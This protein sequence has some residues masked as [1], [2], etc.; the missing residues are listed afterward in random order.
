MIDKQLILHTVGH[1]SVDAICAAVIF[2]HISDPIYSIEFSEEHTL[3][4]ILL[5]NLLAFATQPVAGRLLDQKAL[6]SKFVSLSFIPLMVAALPLLNIW[7]KIILLGI[8]NSMFHT[9]AGSIVIK[10]ETDK[11]AP[12][13]IFVSSGALGL[14]TGTIFG[15]ETI[16]IPLLLVLLF[17]MFALSF[18]L[19]DT[20]PLRQIKL[21]PPINEKAVFF[22]SICIAIRSFFGFLP[23]T[24]FSKTT[25][26]A[27]MIACGVFLGK[28]TGGI[29]ADKFSIKKTVV[30]SSALAIAL[31]IPAIN[32]SVFWS[33]VQLFMNISMPITLFLMC[34]AMPGRPG[35]AF[36][37]AAACL[38]PGLLATASNEKFA[39]STFAYLPV[40]VINAVLILLALKEIQETE[41]THNLIA[42]INTRINQIAEKE[43]KLKK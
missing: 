37:W 36:G 12:L 18:E 22:L 19:P 15:G 9:A 13:G 26:T 23:V 35:L 10:K 17:A 3:C 14:V 24:Q 25:F 1:F 33:A 39:N 8:G 29:I 31:F 20:T 16:T 7:V 34:K 43:K 28:F 2:R 6:V 38:L 40:L 41:E 5:Y 27:Y 21:L 11:A 32:N 42:K 4:M 30:I